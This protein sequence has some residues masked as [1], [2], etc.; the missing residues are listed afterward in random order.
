[1][2]HFVLLVQYQTKLDDCGRLQIG[3][4]IVFSGDP[5]TLMAGVQ[6]C[7][8]AHR[9]DT[10]GHQLQDG[11]GVVTSG[12]LGG[13]ELNFGAVGQSVGQVVTGLGAGRA[14][15]TSVV[16]LALSRGVVMARGLE[17]VRVLM[18]NSIWVTGERIG[19]NMQ[20]KSAQHC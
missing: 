3:L 10:V 17:R 13:A 6:H 11:W 7:F 14:A 2:Y 20:T 1:M 15:A 16:P 12:I 8:R 18:V 19:S 5:S 9:G 4:N